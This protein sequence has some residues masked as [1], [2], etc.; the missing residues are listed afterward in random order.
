M[1]GRGKQG[2]S[3]RL[4][5]LNSAAPTL[6]LSLMVTQASPGMGSVA[7]P[8]A[9]LRMERPGSGFCYM[10]GSDGVQVMGPLVFH[11]GS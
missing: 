8:N 1:K 2:N 10:R 6:V 3:G 9:S 11:L 5:A 4:W 7:S